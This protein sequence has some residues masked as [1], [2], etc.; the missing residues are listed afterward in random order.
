M[1]K[2]YWKKDYPKY[3]ERLDRVEQKW[4]DA[5]NFKNTG[6]CP[7]YILSV[8][9]GYYGAIGAVADNYYESAQVQFEDQ[10]DKCMWHLENV[11]DDWVPGFRPFLSNCVIPSVLGSKIRFTNV[12][13][14][15]VDGSKGYLLNEPE[16]ILELIKIKPDWTKDG[17]G[18][19]A[20]EM[21]DYAKAHT[22]MIVGPHYLQGPLST[23][24]LLAGIAPLMVWMYEEPELV[25]QLMDYLTDLIIDWAML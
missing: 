12:E 8:P 5:Y 7:H 21:I 3:Q 4:K 20:L 15:T 19:M 17:L 11:D 18:P 6:D 23:A 2:Y 10:M 9:E 25:H 24:F 13:D 16:D 22:D 1:E 14:P